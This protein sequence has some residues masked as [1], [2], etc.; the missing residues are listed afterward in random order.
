MMLTIYTEQRTYDVHNNTHV[1]E[2]RK[3]TTYQ[4]YY[5]LTHPHKTGCR[6]L[7]QEGCNTWLMEFSVYGRGQSRIKPVGDVKELSVIIKKQTC[8]HLLNWQNLGRM[9]TKLY[10]CA[11]I[12]CTLAPLRL[13]N[14]VGDTPGEPVTAKV[15]CLQV[16]QIGTSGA[17]VHFCTTRALTDATNFLTKNNLK[18][19]KNLT[20]FI[21]S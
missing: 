18:T 10:V 6:T 20:N 14:I 3:F 1:P 2:L 9:T 4:S 15:F 5:I 13:E 16:L 17:S 11:R 7:L 8:S 21:P 19:N 12:V